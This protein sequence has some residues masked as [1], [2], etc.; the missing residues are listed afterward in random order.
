MAS[1]GPHPFLADNQSISVLE[2]EC[3]QLT[4]GSL[5]E[6]DDVVHA[7]TSSL[8][9]ELYSSNPIPHERN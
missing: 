3:R 7:Y 9:S 4:R 5:R 2:L 6:G 1:Y 8:L